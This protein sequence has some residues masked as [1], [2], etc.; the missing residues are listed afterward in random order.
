MARHTISEPEA[1]AEST[2]HDSVVAVYDSHAA[3]E[4]AVRELECGVSRRDSAW[5]LRIT[6]V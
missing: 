3:A 4:A 1:P 5:L 6:V 2:E